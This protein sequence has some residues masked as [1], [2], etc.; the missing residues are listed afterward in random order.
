MAVLE[1]TVTAKLDG[2]PL[3]QFGLPLHHRQVVDELQA[4]GPYT[5][6]DDGDDTTFG[7]IPS[8]E[9]ATI[10]ALLLKP[11]AEIDFRIN[12]QSDARLTITGTG[13]L[14]IG[15]A[16]INDGASTNVTANAN[17]VTPNVV[18]FAAGT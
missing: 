12:G 7:S 9:I 3:E 11:D 14:L 5:K 1:I 6:A 18:G 8:Q 17:G 15:G 10:Q 13:F 2:K 16:T 4:V